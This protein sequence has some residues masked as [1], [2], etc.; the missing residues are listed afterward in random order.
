MKKMKKITGTILIALFLLS[1]QLNTY[2]QGG[3]G[4]VAKEKKELPK[5]KKSSDGVI[6]K[7][8]VLKKTN[9]EN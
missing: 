1:I 8:T 6:K 4:D 3:I 7:D 5:I 9:Q 2:G